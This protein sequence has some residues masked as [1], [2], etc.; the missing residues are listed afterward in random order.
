MRAKGSRILGLD[1]RERFCDGF[2]CIF[3]VLFNDIWYYMLFLHVSFLVFFHDFMRLS[4]RLPF[5]CA[6]GFLFGAVPYLKEFVL[7]LLC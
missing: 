2:M 1:G 4:H 5:A 7:F 6:V 3:L